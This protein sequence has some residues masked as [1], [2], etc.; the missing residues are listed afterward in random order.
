MPPHPMDGDLRHLRVLIAN[1]KRDRLELL[2]RFEG[3][4]RVTVVWIETKDI[5][6][7]K[8]LV[9]HAVCAFGGESVMLTAVAGVVRLRLEFPSRAV[10]AR[11]VEGIESWLSQTGIEGQILSSPA[12]PGRPR[13][14]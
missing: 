2:A 9:Q 8:Q 12:M 3:G 14:W 13:A 11:V 5:A 6:T 4:S 10:A 1:E 7:A